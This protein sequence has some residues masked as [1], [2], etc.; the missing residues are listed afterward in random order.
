MNTSQAANKPKELKKEDLPLRVDSTTPVERMKSRR[1]L[2]GFVVALG[3]IPLLYGAYLII[4]GPEYIT[5]NRFS[6]P[7]FWEIIRLN[8]GA[9]ASIGFCMVAGGR[10]IRQ[11]GLQILVSYID[12]HFILC[13]E[14]GRPSEEEQLIVQA[15][16]DSHFVIGHQKVEMTEN[17]NSQKP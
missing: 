17:K 14:F 12:D 10:L 13:N 8:P 5:V 11:S 16:E 3:L 15:I 4:F 1:T 2:G 7:N 6:G 9:V